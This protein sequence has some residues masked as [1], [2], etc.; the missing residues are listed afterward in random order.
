MLITIKN[1]SQFPGFGD[2]T[3][4]RSVRYLRQYKRKKERETMIESV[5]RYLFISFLFYV[6]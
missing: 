3:N 1:R 5:E 2:Q 4:P 6:Y